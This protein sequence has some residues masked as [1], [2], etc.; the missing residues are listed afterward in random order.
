MNTQNVTT[1]ALFG[2]F[3]AAWD[4]YAVQ[5]ALAAVEWAKVVACEFALTTEVSEADLCGLFLANTS[6]G[7][8]YRVEKALV[9]EGLSA[10][11]PRL[12]SFEIIDRIQK[13]VQRLQSRAQYN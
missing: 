10:G 13:R 6:V 9:A 4:F 12:R 11:K 2:E 8:Q 5:H 7:N 1:V 3:N